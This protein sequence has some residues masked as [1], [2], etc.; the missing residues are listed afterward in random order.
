MKLRNKKTGEIKK[1]WNDNICLSFGDCNKV[2]Y[3]LKEL[4]E[5]WEDY[6]PAK[7]RIKDEKARRA[8][9]EWADYNGVK[10]VLYITDGEGGSKLDA[11]TVTIS[12]YNEMTGLKDWER[13]T[14]TELCGEEEK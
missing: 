8:I 6:K 4:N 11:H 9:R 12:F 3:S 14:I 5:D 10:E 13:Y 7:P 2:Y 1:M